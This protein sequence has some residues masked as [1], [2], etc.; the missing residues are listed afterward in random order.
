MSKP[1]LYQQTTWSLQP[2]SAATPG[3]SIGI[4]NHELGTPMKVLWTTSKPSIGF[5]GNVNSCPNLS[6]Q[7]YPAWSPTKK[8]C[9]NTCGE[10]LKIARELFHFPIRGAPNMV[11]KHQRNLGDPDGD[12][13]Q[14]L[15]LPALHQPKRDQSVFLGKVCVTHLINTT[16]FFWDGFVM[17]SPEG[18]GFWYRMWGAAESAGSMRWPNMFQ[19][20]SFIHGSWRCFYLETARLLKEFTVNYIG[21]WSPPHLPD[22]LSI[23]LGLRLHCV[24]LHKIGT[25]KRCWRISNAK[26]EGNR[27]V[28]QTGHCSA[29]HSDLS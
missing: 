26:R 24:V 2:I 19:D 1:K 21:D 20:V 3:W 17:P 9:S 18:D 12:T 15:C 14:A 27:Q 7:R 16:L 25:A 11:H 5:R 13:L 23:C 4:A 8:T 29:F 10:C 6:S 28:W 22:R